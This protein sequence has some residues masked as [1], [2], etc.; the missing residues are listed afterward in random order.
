MASLGVVRD[1]NSAVVLDLTRRQRSVSRAEVAAH[2]GLSR[3]TIASIINGLLADGLLQETTLPPDRLGRPGTLLELNPAGGCAVGV[4]LGVDF[5]SVILTD[6][7]AHVLWHQRASTDPAD[8][9]LQILERAFALT[10]SAL[11]DGAMRGLRPLGIG[12]GVPGLVDWQAG[13]LRLAPKLGW[14]NTPL[15]LMWT[16][17]FNLPIFVENHGNAAALGEYYFGAAR[18]VN[19]VVYLDVG[20][21]LGAG[22][23]IGGKLFRG[24]HGYATEIGHMV[25]DPNGELCGCGNR[26]CLETMVG[27]HSMVRRVR[28]TLTQPGQPSRL[29]MAGQSLVQITVDQVIEAARQGDPTALAALQEVGK[30]L[31]I[32][33]VNLMNIFNPE[34]VVLGGSLNLANE[35]LLPIVG[36]MISTRALGIVSEDVKI[37]PSAHGA[38][39]CAMGAVALVLNDTLRE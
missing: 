28:Q 34:L 31:G 22:V 27:S 3:S 10:Q 29:P 15:R 2:T 8:G 21:S 18:G 35:I 13:L 1:F 38:E 11:D 26:G 16:Q 6:F 5:I 30:Y 36:Q 9:Q 4:E 39:A 24:S 32:G 14:R 33:I 17:R 37:I 7:A 19:N 20:V 25:L 23:L 12:V